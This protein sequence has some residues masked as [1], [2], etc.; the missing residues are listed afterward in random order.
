MA[1]LVQVS[2]A[3]GADYVPAEDLHEREDD[4]DLPELKDEIKTMAGADGFIKPFPRLEPADHPTVRELFARFKSSGARF[5]PNVPVVNLPEYDVVAQYRY[6]VFPEDGKL[7][8]DA[9][10]SPDAN[11]LRDILDDPVPGDKVN[12]E[13]VYCACA[14]WATSTERV[15]VLQIVVNLYQKCSSLDDSD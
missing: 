2:T 8:P 4:D 12:Q 10:L 5:Y 15:N 9:L 14:F 7:T 1:N 3:A 11:N 13:D 6:R